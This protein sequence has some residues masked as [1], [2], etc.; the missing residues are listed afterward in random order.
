[1]IDRFSKSSKTMRHA[2]VAQ[3]PSFYNDEGAGLVAFTE[4][5]FQHLETDVLAEGRTLQ[6]TGDIDTAA[7]K[8]LI[9]F[10]NKYTFGSGRSIRNLPSVITGDIRFIIKHI[11]D[12]YRSKGTDRGVRL[13]FRVAFNDDP[14]IFTPGTQL[15]RASDSTFRRPDIIEITTGAGLT[16]DQIN[17][18]RGQRIV[19]SVSGA[20][21]SVNDVFIKRVGSKQYTYMSLNN[22]TGSF[23][24]KDKITLPSPTQSDIAVAPEVT[25]PV[26]DA[27][28][29]EGSLGIPAGTT[30]TS[31]DGRELKVAA[32]EFEFVAGTFELR[33]VDGSKYSNDASVVIT[34]AP[35]EDDA[36]QR[37]VFKVTVDGLDGLRNV[38]GSIVQPYLSQT[39]NST[40]M[41]GVPL[42]LTDAMSTDLSTESRLFGSIQNVLAIDVPQL[43]TKTPFVRIEDI[44]FSSTQG[45]TISITNTE[46]TGS[47][48]AFAGLMLS[49]MTPTGT[50]NVSFRDTT[51]YGTGANFTQFSPDDVI[52]IEDTTGAGRYLTIKTIVDDNE[53]EV[54]EAPDFVSHGAAFGP[55]HKNYIKIADSAGN[56]VIRVVNNAVSDTSLFLDDEIITTD[57]LLATSGLTYKIGQS[58]KHSFDRYGPIVG[59]DA[60]FKTILS[61]GEGS[62][63]KIGILNAGFG[64]EQAENVSMVSEDLTPQISFTNTDGRGAAAFISL[65]S[66]QVSSVT[67]TNAGSGY[68]TAPVVAVD[69]GTGTGAKLEAVVSNGTIA[70]INITNPGSGYNPRSIII[71]RPNKGGQSILEGR[72]TRV[73]SETS[74]G[75]RIQDSDFWQEYSYQIQS[76]IDG[77]EYEDVVDG[78]MHMAGRKLFTKP[79]IRDTQAR[80]AVVVDDS[81]STS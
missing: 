9:N 50:A 22:I 31:M 40:T 8:Y 81:V 10:N 3:F 42:V 59:Q 71:V 67:I 15:F 38:N 68:T 76:S 12:I 79:S 57:G 70:S 62:V 53:L 21:A 26:N 73:G 14:E 33:P 25:G 72:A 56:E 69:G 47:G 19:G 6:E 45:G 17:A 13:F 11:K 74:T 24:T 49:T 75:L 51:V 29:V 20:R 80:K 65:T 35:L 43:Y 4:K 44:A 52:R 77:S 61:A 34:R 66:G 23:T 37:G 54:M 63:K 28:I 16:K 41:F 1:M 46:V 27:T 18:Y 2:V 55:S 58:S 48:T 39:I 60:V 5:Y 78:L 7:E 30:F 36:I 64:Y 32:T